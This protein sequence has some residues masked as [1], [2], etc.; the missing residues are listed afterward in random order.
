MLSKSEQLK[1]PLTPYDPPTV[2]FYESYNMLYHSTKKDGVLNN[3]HKE[4]WPTIGMLWNLYTQSE[5]SFHTSKLTPRLSLESHMSTFH[6]L[7]ALF[8]DV[9]VIL[10]ECLKK[11]PTDRE[12]LAI[13]SF[14]EEY[15]VR[16]NNF[17]ELM[18]QISP[19]HVKLQRHFYQLVALTPRSVKTNNL[20]VTK[21]FKPLYRLRNEYFFNP[22]LRVLEDYLIASNKIVKRRYYVNCVISKKSTVE[23]REAQFSTEASLVELETEVLLKALH[24]N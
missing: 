20:K 10:K 9:V 19:A 4:L 13:S 11:A 12:K 3:Y 7:E 18:G 8:K 15:V 2:M 24:S 23:L 1:L 16:I 5:L 22:E 17:Q 21:F 6:R 14:I